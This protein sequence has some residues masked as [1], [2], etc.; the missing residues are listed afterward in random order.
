MKKFLNYI[1]DFKHNPKNF[2]EN[3]YERKKRKL[4]KDGKSL[5]KLVNEFNLKDTPD[6]N[7]YRS[8]IL[9]RDS[10]DYQLDHVSFFIIF[11]RI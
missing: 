1:Q 4:F 11:I 5:S 2:D 6:Q 9:N 7:S 10:V 8:N 3:D